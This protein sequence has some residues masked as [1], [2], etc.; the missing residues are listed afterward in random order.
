MP[1]VSTLGV[2]T[3]HHA[4]GG[5]A[6]MVLAKHRTENRMTPLLRYRELDGREHVVE[7][8]TPDVVALMA[9]LVRMFAAERPEI[10]EW[11]RQLT[12][13]TEWCAPARPAPR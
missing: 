8:S 10:A 2:V 9:S 12:A 13:G 1:S 7:L 6:E 3:L 5:T 4:A 11:Y